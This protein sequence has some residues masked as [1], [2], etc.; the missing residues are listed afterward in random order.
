[1]PFSK[2]FLQF[3][4]L[5]ASSL[6]NRVSEVQAELCICTWRGH[7]FI[8]KSATSGTLRC[9]FRALA[10]SGM[11]A[12]SSEWP[13]WPRGEQ[14][15]SSCAGESWAPGRRR[16]P[17]WTTPPPSRRAYSS[18]WVLSLLTLGLSSLPTKFSGPFSLLLIS[19]PS[20][21]TKSLINV[22]P[23]SSFAPTKD[24]LGWNQVFIRGLRGFRS[25]VV[26]F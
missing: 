19:L 24:I 26:P 17:R 11:G 13:S 18:G 2:Y 9:P 12:S 22:T 16:S 21:P 15:C 8:W 10:C 23:P 6:K 4:I 25:L 3:R 20:T 1:M 7:T 14:G 5:T